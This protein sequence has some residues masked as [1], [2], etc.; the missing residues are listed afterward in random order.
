MIYK[1][2]LK[3]DTGKENEFFLT[4]ENLNALYRRIL[5]T[6]GI[7]KDK[8][9]L[10]EEY[11]EVGTS[12][13]VF[14]KSHVKKDEVDKEIIKKAKELI[15]NKKRKPEPFKSEYKAKHSM[16]EFPVTK[17]SDL[18]DLLAKYSTVRVCWEPTEKRGEHTMYAL[19]K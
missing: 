15:A 11:K 7:T 18:Y 16:I 10:L 1:F 9:V 4:A 6:Y 5:S 17:E 3:V 2:A 19:V 13:V 12:G 14:V 8:V